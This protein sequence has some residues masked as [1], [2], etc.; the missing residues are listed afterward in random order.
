MK[1]TIKELKLSYFKGCKDL[2][3]NFNNETVISGMNASG[4]TTVFDAF[5]WLLFDKDSLNRS[6][7][8]IKTLSENGKPIPSVEH[9]VEGVLDVDGQLLRLRKTLKE[10][11]TKKRG[12][13][14]PEFSGHATEYFINEVP[15][16]A[17]DYK[18]RID[19]L[20]K[21]DLFKLLSNP[22]HFNEVLN[23]KQ[24]RDILLSM[25]DDK[26]I[27]E[28]LMNDPKYEKLPLHQYKLDEIRAMN[29]STAKKTNEGLKELPAR[30]DELQK[31]KVVVDK[32]SVQRQLDKKNDERDFL[33]SYIEAEDRVEK[34]RREVQQKINALIFEGHELL[35]NDEKEW[36]E[37][38]RQKTNEQSKKRNELH[39]NKHKIEDDIFALD[40][41]ILKNKNTIEF[42]KGRIDDTQKVFNDWSEQVFNE[43]ERCSLCGQ[44][45]PENEKDV[46]RVKFNQA[47]SENME[48]CANSIKEWQQLLQDANA[49]LEILT[50]ELDS[51]KEN[52]AIHEQSYNDFCESIKSEEVYEKSLEVQRKEHEIK[53]QIQELQEKLPQLP[54]EESKQKAMDQYEMLSNEITELQLQLN[55]DSGNAAIEEKIQKYL[56]DEKELARKYEQ[57]QEIL[58]LC[59]EYTKDYVQAITSNINE[60]F[61]NVS[62]KLFDT[63]IN[64][65]IVETC[66]ATVCGVPY[67]DV[68]NAGKI[69]AGIDIINALSKHHGISVPVFIDNAESINEV[70]YTESQTVKLV[71]SDSSL[72]QVR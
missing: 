30:I 56:K 44:P 39:S 33:K 27:S 14:N 16:R 4:K 62:F 38:E 69:N 32:D 20:V 71:V 48:E 29:A 49:R 67:S 53:D 2:T 46:L 11:W 8:E 1:I 58:F 52:L 64:G 23:K 18:D 36:Y 70:A 43:D 42:L 3:V 66:E 6:D 17:R 25:F 15:V 41:K 59:D 24:R 13:I 5:C 51:K 72:L 47:K 34:Q 21:E 54:M 60:L 22:R 57:A 35:R 28:R 63:Q 45:L 19:T 65:G 7:F 55:A 40:G 12:S 26:S 31:M 50:K 9:T 10:V 61:R 37:K 68:N